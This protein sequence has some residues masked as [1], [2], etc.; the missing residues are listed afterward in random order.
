[1]FMKDLKYLH[2]YSESLDFS[3]PSAGFPNK[4]LHMVVL[5]NCKTPNTFVSRF[6]DLP[7]RRVSSSND[8]SPIL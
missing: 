5:I 4:A 3:K 6:A 8:R 2:S 7:S 1:M